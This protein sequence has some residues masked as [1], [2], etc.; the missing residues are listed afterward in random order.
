MP[1]FALVV[2]IVFALFCKDSEK[3]NNIKKKFSIS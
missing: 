3:E 2:Q 1:S